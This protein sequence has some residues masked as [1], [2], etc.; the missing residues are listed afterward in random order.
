VVVLDD[1]GSWKEYWALSDNQ[2]SIDQ[3]WS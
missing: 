2:E 3:F 1:E